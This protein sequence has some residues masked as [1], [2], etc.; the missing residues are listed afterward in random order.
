MQRVI[1]LFILI[2]LSAQTI[3]QETSP[4]RQKVQE[5]MMS[6]IRT[7][8]DK[9]RDIYRKPGLVLEFFGLEENA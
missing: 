7:G 4:I 6:D 9:A 5:A 1:T 8:E 2:F 3:A